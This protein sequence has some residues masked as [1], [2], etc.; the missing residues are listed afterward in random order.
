[1]A[2]AFGFPA[3]ELG[4]YMR[5]GLGAFGAIDAGRDRVNLVEQGQVEDVLTNP[6]TEY[7]SKLVRAAFEVEA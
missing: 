4:A 3:F 7:T 6:Q 5:I 1:M 2:V